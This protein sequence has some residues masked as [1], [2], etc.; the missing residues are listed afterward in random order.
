MTAS[1][2]RPHGNATVAIRGGAHELRV[3]RPPGT[4]ARLH[5]AGGVSGLTID[6]LELGAVGGHVRWESPG[7]EGAADRWDIEVRGG[8]RRVTVGTAAQA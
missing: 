8:A 3:V 2:P 4:A 1:L 5:I 7:F 6:T